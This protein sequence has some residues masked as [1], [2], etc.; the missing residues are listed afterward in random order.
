MTKFLAV[1]LSILLVLS[2][3]GTA[4]A[5]ASDKVTT[6][7]NRGGKNI[8]T[9]PL[10]IPKGVIQTTKESNV[11]FGVLFGPIRGLCNFFSK[12][13]SGVTDIATSTTGSQDEPLLKPEMIEGSSTSAK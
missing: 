4:M 5:K 12:V 7:V 6:K 11:I 8:L 9:A 2:M 13:T 10:E 1:A 3:T